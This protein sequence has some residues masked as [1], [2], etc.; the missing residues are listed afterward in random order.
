M[1]NAGP[2]NRVHLV[3]D[4]GG[5][6]CRPTRGKQKGSQESGC[7]SLHPFP[8]D[9]LQP[10]A[11]CSTHSELCCRDEKLEPSDITGMSLPVRADV[12]GAYDVYQ[13]A[14]QSFIDGDAESALAMADEWFA[15]R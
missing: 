1:L 12:Q 14:V 6:L 8:V 15:T 11:A 9:E 3:W 4:T 7:K 5:H 2:L 13:S 10:F